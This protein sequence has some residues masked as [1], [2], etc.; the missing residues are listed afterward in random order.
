MRYTYAYSNDAPMIHLNINSFS[1]LK[2]C[3]TANSA[4]FRLFAGENLANGLIM[5]NECLL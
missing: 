5:V 4:T 2:Y 1:T 3:I